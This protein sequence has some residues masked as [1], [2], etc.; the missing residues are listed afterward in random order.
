MSKIFEKVLA[1]DLS[2]LSACMEECT[3]FLEETGIPADATFAA[4]LSLE[5]MITNS[6]KYGYEEEDAHEITVRISVEPA[7]FTLEI[8]DDGGEFDPF[9]QAPPDLSLPAEERPIGGL[10]IHLV[11]NL[12]TSCH[13]QR[14]NGVNHVTLVKSWSEEN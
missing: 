2:A 9:I 6:I 13:Y 8:F 1:A 4:N 12:M 3:T 7:Q 5:E 14:E 10:G 11:K